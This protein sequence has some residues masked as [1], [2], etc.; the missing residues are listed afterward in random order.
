[1]F[2][3]E[4]VFEKKNEKNPVCETVVWSLAD[5]VKNLNEKKWPS[6]S[7]SDM[8]TGG[9]SLVYI[10]VTALAI[11]E[12]TIFVDASSGRLLIYTQKWWSPVTVCYQS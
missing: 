11:C 3:V 9:L 7:D 8:V 5:R 12:E 6:L 4:N 1:M 10:R 2:R